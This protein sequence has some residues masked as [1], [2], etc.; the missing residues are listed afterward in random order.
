MRV[1]IRK[2]IHMYVYETIF[3][4]TTSRAYSCMCSNEYIYICKFIYISLSSSDSEPPQSILLTSLSQP[5]ATRP[6]SDSPQRDERGPAGD[7]PDDADRW[8]AAGALAALAPAAVEETVY[9]LK[10]R[11]HDMFFF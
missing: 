5:Y 11:P 10:R 8:A 1:C 7:A 3:S 4:I 9:R 2:F 6:T